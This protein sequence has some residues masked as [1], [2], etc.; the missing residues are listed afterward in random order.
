MSETL[1][2]LKERADKLGVKYS[3]NIGESKLQEKINAAII[4]ESEKPV[5]K[6]ATAPTGNQRS[7]HY[8]MVNWMR[9]P[10]IC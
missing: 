6:A 3:P 1:D 7:M 2:L 10:P 5:K 4:A 9:R 8:W